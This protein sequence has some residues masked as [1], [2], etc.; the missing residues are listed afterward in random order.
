MINHAGYENND[1]K[2]PHKVDT[3]IVE[4]FK[5]LKW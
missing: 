2:Q 3:Q 1:P 5:I 4:N